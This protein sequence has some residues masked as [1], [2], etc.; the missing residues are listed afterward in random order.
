MPA[1]PRWGQ[2]HDPAPRLEQRVRRNLMPTAPRLEQ[3]PARALLGQRALLRLKKQM[4][5]ARAGS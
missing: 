2:R 3:R 5:P 1:A 4:S